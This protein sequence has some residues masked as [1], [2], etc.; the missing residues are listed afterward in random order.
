MQPQSAKIEG[1]PV[2]APGKPVGA[3]G[4]ASR[5]AGPPALKEWGLG[6]EMD[7]WMDGWMDGRTAGWVAALSGLG[8]SSRPE[9]SDAAQRYT[10]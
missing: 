5:G 10:G 6:G 7:G 8:D 4:K 9:P 2:G 3:P 1:K